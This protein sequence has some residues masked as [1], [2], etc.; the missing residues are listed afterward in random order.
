MR[1]TPVAGALALAWPLLC[2]FHVSAEDWPIYTLPEIVVTPDRWPRPLDSVSQAV[3]VLDRAAIEASGVAD[4]PAL[5]RLEAGVEVAATGGLGNSAALRLRGAESDHVLVLID[6]VR[7]SSA[8]AGTTAIDQIMLDAIE[9]I[10]IV[11]G[12]VSSVYGSEAIGG[13]VQVFTRRGDGP[14][15]ARAR[16]AMGA[17]GFRSWSAGLDGEMGATRFSMGVGRVSSDG[18]SSAR[19]EFVPSA[20]VFA[21]SDGDDDG[22][23][24]TTWRFS[25]S[26]HMAAGHEIGLSALRSDG[27]VEYDGT[28]SNHSDQAVSS[29][30]LYAD[31]QWTDGWRGRVQIGQ[32]VDELSSDLDGVL[33]ERLKT[34]NRQL[35]WTNR[36][37]AGPGSL[38][39]G[40]GGLW[41]KLTASG[42]FARD[43]R[44]AAS[45]F[46]GYLA[47]LGVHEAQLNL[48]YDDYSDIGPATTGLLGYGYRISPRLRAVASYSTAFKAPTF[49]ELYS[50]AFAPF[51]VGNP[52]LDPERARSVEIGLSYAGP[53]GRARA[54]L[55]ETR[56]RDLIAI[57][58][59]TFATVVNLDR[60]RNRGLELTWSGSVAGLDTRA[61]LTFQNAED[62]TTG[63]GLLRRADR[64]GSLGLGRRAGKF[65]WQAELR[66]SGPRPDVHATNFTRTTVPGYAV[67]DL[68]AGWRAARDWRLSARLANVL[69]KDYSEVHG[70]NTQGRALFLE[71]TRQPDR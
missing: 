23:D 2:P 7:V 54:T 32:G 29:A 6:G 50:Q 68:R 34:R 46:G 71:L 27:S 1:M 4:L 35:T 48:R 55:F 64:F 3:T 8:S 25:L 36:I 39:L 12:N 40:V 10:E 11:R 37:D 67:L 14:V 19:A 43:E 52:N 5:L 59:V 45:V 62:E 9:R 63:Q 44:R 61:A 66:A 38:Q 30:S 42:A 70:Y 58:P 17:E 49:T 22:Y 15:R 65:D 33:V 60:A 31:H 57:D 28:T 24:N 51:F 26:R 16:M 47:T 21:P 18:F 13:V 69:D 56:T 41:Q 20:F 53:S